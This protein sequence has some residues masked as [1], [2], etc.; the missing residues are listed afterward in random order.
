MLSVQSTFCGKRILGLSLYVDAFTIDWRPYFIYAFPPFAIIPKIFKK[1][2][3]EGSRG[4]LVVPKWPSQAWYPRVMAMFESPPI[5]FK[6]KANLLFSSNRELHPLP[7][8]LSLVI[9]IL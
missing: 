6:P 9:G 1:V 3:E 4:I 7:S 2:N 8:Q 5:I